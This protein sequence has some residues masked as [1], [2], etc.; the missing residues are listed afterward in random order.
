[1]VCCHAHLYPLSDGSSIGHTLSERLCF[2]FSSTS[3]TQRTR[4]HTARRKTRIKNRFHLSTICT[5]D[6]STSDTH[7]VASATPETPHNVI[8]LSERKHGEKSEEDTLE[9][10]YYQRASRAPSAPGHVSAVNGTRKPRFLKAHILL[11]ANR[12]CKHSSKHAAKIPHHVLLYSMN[13]WRDTP[14]H[15]EQYRAACT[16][17][18]SVP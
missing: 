9:K 2:N 7:I 18:D 17:L 10:T 1:M 15:A 13:K 16:A 12:S 6:L 8:Q 3:A 4:A 5:A 14:P 11:P